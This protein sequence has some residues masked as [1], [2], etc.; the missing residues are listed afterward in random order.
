MQQYLHQADHPRVMDLNSGN[1]RL[2]D[3][4]RESRALEQREVD[5]NVEQFGLKARQTIGGDDQLLTQGG[6]I[7]Q[8]LVQAEILHPVDADLYAQEG[9]EF[10]VHAGH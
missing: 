6:Q 2:A 4:N 10:F 8:S 3:H 7:L 5:L 9:G 1:L